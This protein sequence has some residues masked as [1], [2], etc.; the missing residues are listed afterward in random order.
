LKLQPNDFFFLC[1]KELMIIPCP[2]RSLSDEGREKIM[3]IFERKRSAENQALME[4][5]R[6]EKR[7]CRLCLNLMERLKGD[8]NCVEVEDYPPPLLQL[9]R[10]K[11]NIREP[12]SISTSINIQIEE[13]ENSFTICRKCRMR[14]LRSINWV[15]RRA[16]IG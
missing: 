8:L 1:A 13:F 10:Q 14:S 5:L 15:L 3:A 7:V 12:R 2:F 4:L 9:L 16:Y 6:E 11:A